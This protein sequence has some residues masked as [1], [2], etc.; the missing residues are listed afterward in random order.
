MLC[1]SAAYGLTDFVMFFSVEMRNFCTICY[2]REVTIAT[3]EVTDETSDNE[4]EQPKYLVSQDS[5]QVVTAHK[6]S[7]IVRP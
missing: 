6:V 3:S 5:M 1:K 4:L 2:I 7:S